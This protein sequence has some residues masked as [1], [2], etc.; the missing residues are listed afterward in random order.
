MQ[1]LARR[2]AET[3]HG[4]KVA[5]AESI[6]A[7]R[8]ATSLAA[9]PDASEWFWGSVVAYHTGMKRELLGVTSTTIISRDCARQ[10][11]QGL[12]DRTGAELVVATT[13][14]GGPDPEEGRPPGTVVICAGTADGLHVFEHRFD[15]SPEE[16]VE[17]ATVEALR[18]LAEAAG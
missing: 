5:A 10:M 17:Q 12:L 15:G 9:A 2:L 13:G 18:H 7:G 8:I 1:E 11:A 6:T 16:V 14:V 4:R 3:T